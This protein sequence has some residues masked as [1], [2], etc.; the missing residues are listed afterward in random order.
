MINRNN[1]YK[2]VV[3]E[4]SADGANQ[5]VLELLNSFVKFLWGLLG[6]VDE[7]EWKIFFQNFCCG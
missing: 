5:N 3:E 2:L 6:L 7:E 4:A 1:Y